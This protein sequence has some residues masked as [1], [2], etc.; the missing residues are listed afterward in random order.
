M[1]RLPS[2]CQAKIIEELQ[3]QS[4]PPLRLQNGSKRGLFVVV[5]RHVL[6]CGDGG[7]DVGALKQA[8]ND[9][10]LDVSSSCQDVHEASTPK[11]G[12]NMTEL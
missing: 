6:M 3:K 8:T 10:P 5:F 1:K 11:V 12:C 4:R 2:F 9:Q 7:N